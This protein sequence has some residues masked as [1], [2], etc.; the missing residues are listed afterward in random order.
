MTTDPSYFQIAF[1][2]VSPLAAFLAVGTAYLALYRQSKPNVL[3]YYEPSND[4]ASV[5][6]LVICNY[7]G[8]VAR[9][10][11]LSK[12]IPIGCWGIEKPEKVDKSNF[13]TIFIPVLAPGKSIRYQAGQYEGLYSQIGDSFPVTTTYKFETPLRLRKNGSDLSILDIRFMARMHS[14]N[15]AAQDLS[16]AMKGRNN[17]VF[18]DINKSLV[19]ISTTLNKINSVLGDKS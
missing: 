15:S 8:G 6:D 13:L 5:I 19:T 14:A 12:P 3:V 17:T 7:G 4:V 10:I 18:K 11:E 1:Y 16:D 9:D 2:I